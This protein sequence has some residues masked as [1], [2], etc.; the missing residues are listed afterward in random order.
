MGDLLTA[1]D[2]QHLAS[3]NPVRASHA[4]IQRGKITVYH[5]HDS[6]YDNIRSKISS[7]ALELVQIQI[8]APRPQKACR[9]VFHSIYGII[10]GWTISIGSKLEMD[11]FDREWWLQVDISEKIF[12]IESEFMCIH[13]IAT[14]GGNT[15]NGLLQQLHGN[16]SS[17]N[18]LILMT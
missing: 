6:I 8:S 3:K 1:V 5:R 10:C 17:S 2:N 18:I 15:A 11:D 13:D 7:T 16:A 12:P 14:L 9:G 4:T